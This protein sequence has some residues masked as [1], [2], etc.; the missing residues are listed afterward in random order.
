ML[1]HPKRAGFSLEIP[2]R[3]AHDFQDFTA[4]IT[5]ACCGPA[6]VGPF[7]CTRELSIHGFGFRVYRVLRFRARFTERLQGLIF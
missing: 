3:P 7:D 4:E 2:T 1:R 5:W 6:V